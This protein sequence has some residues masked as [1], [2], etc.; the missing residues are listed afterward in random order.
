MRENSESVIVLQ[1]DSLFRSTVSSFRCGYHKL[2]GKLKDLWYTLRSHDL[3]WWFANHY[4][5]GDLIVNHLFPF[6]GTRTASPR[7]R[8]GERLSVTR[9]WRYIFKNTTCWPA[10]AHD[11]TTGV[12]QYKCRREITSSAFSSSLTGLF[13]ETCI[14]VG[15][16]FSFIYHGE[17]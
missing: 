9:V 5:G 3:K 12:P 7:G 6:M 14:L 10:R 16:Q 13:E 15:I 4:S 1:N 2:F 8:Y 17:H 11:V